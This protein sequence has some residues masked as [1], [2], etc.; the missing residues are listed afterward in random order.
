MRTQ[1]LIKN[2]LIT[3]IATTM[4]CS[5]S[6]EKDNGV[7]GHDFANMFSLV[8]KAGNDLLDPQSPNHYNTPETI[9]IYR[10]E[11]GEKVLQYNPMSG[12]PYAFN[13]HAPEDTFKEKYLMSVAQSWDISEEFAVVYVEW[14]AEETDTIEYQ[15]ELIYN[16]RLKLI[17]IWYNGQLVWSEDN[18]EDVANNPQRLFEI[19]K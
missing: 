2:A 7:P 16:S 1:Y 19:V 12:S 10:L 14:N 4:L 3:L 6:E 9:R 18:P 15:R 11:D 13:I 5:C 17:N 8:D